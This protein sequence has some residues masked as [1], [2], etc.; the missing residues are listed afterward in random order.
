MAKS[1]ITFDGFI[2][3]FLCG[4]S[5]DAYKYLGC[6]KN[7]EGFVFRVW[8]P[9][10]KSVRLTGD[11]NGWNINDIYM[12]NLGSGIWEATAENAKIYDNYKYCIESQDGRTVLKSDPYAFHSCTRPENASKIYDISAYKWTDNV[13]MK[14]RKKLNHFESPMNIYEVHLGSWMRYPDGNFYNYR[15]LAKKLAKY[16][17]DMGYTH[18]EIMPVSEYPFDPLQ[19]TMHP[20]PA[21]AR[22]RI[23]PRLWILCTKTALA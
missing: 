9:R 17:K 18:I 6:H 19:G 7:K 14:N 4:N 20:H 5:I 3:D 21:M 13:Y 2:T 22:P 15:D 8:A 12:K 11:F 10:A 23:L 1:K 16:V